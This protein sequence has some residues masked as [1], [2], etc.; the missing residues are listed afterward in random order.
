MDTHLYLIRH[1]EALVNVEHIVGGVKGCRGLTPRGHEQAARLGQRLAG[2][3]LGA[4]VLY[5][6]TL[7]RARET[8]A[9]VAQGLGL[10]IIWD[11]E[12]QESR[13]G[14]ADGL[15][16][17]E[18][19][20]RFGPGALTGPYHSSFPGGESQ[21]SFMVRAGVALSRIV[22]QHEGQR[23]VVVAHGGVIEAS[24]T[25]FLGLNPYTYTFAGFDNRHAAITE[26]KLVRPEPNARAR[27]FLARFND[28]R[29]L[30][31]G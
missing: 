18:A 7:L 17:H 23:V 25:L 22:Q 19:H 16:D 10:P 2:G 26:W 30:E 8:A 29:H 4:D 28:V 3:E 11:D 27:W 12:L 15:L 20:V 24:F 9:Y 13:P 5:A 6:S 14:E 1:G 31:G 21:V